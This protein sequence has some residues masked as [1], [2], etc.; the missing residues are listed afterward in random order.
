MELILN[1][2]NTF[3]DIVIGEK[4]NLIYNKKVIYTGKIVEIE[5]FPDETNLKIQGIV[6]NE[7]IREGNE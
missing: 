5:E 7:N 2:N 1:N 6:I 3:S 4:V